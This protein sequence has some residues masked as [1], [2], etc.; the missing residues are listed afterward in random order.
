MNL[1]LRNKTLLFSLT[2]L[3]FILSLLPQKV[4]GQ[5]KEVE[6]VWVN[7]LTKGDAKKLSAFLGAAIT[8]ELPS[9][10]G[11]F[12]KNQAVVMLTEF[13]SIYPAEKVIIKQKGTTSSSAMFFIGEYHCRT[14]EY[15]LYVLMNNSSGDY[16]IHS[17]SITKK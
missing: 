10:N 2:V 9:Q 17:L 14:T 13:F 6:Q 8:L 7:H 4:S 12:S 11:S 16:L 5:E 1:I 3:A 15:R